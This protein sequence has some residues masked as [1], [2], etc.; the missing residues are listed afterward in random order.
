LA[1]DQEAQDF[2]TNTNG[3]APSVPAAAALVF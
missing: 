3:I 1:N 2:I